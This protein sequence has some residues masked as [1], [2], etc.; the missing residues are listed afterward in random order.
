MELRNF[1]LARDLLYAGG[2]LTGIALGYI[3]TLFW[4]DMTIRSRNR[5]ITLIFFVFSGALAAFSAAILVSSGDIFSAGSLFFVAG[6]C[7]PVFALAVCFPRAAAYPLILAGGLL[8]VWLGYSFLR[9]PLISSGSPLLYVSH[10]GDNAYSVRIPAEP[11]ETGDRAAPAGDGTGQSGDRAVITVS[12]ISGNQ[13][14]LTVQ[15]ILISFDPRYPLVGGTER[16][17]ISR[18]RRGSETLYADS[19]TISRRARPGFLGAG[20]QPL[21][22]TVFLDAVPRG[23]NLAVFFDGEALSLRV[24]PR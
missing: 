7:V 6:A 20:F 9:F 22:E 13:P 18:I 8:A 2:A 24:H 5:R 21:E 15:G 3:L 16:G 12:H 4:K 17:L 14:P 11:G 19:R 23:A 10:E 1:S